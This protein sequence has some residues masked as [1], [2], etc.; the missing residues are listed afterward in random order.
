[1]YGEPDI[2]SEIGKG[3]LRWVG[4]ME[5]MLEERTVK[6]EFKNIPEGKRSVGK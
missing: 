1:V 3:K 4:H 2:I 6:K 5:R